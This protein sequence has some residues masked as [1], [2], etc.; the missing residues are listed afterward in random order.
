MYPP[1]IPSHKQHYFLHGWRVWASFAET[2]CVDRSE[3]YGGGSNTGKKH[4]N[5]DDDSVKNL[6]AYQRRSK[7]SEGSVQT[8]DLAPMGTH[9]PP[10]PSS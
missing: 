1:C 5:G 6:Q 10:K 4:E 8:K 7:Q 3:M 2:R 9:D